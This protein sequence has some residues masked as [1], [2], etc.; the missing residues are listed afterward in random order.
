MEEPICL[1]RNPAWVDT[2]TRPEC[3]YSPVVVTKNP[4]PAA[5]ESMQEVLSTRIRV[6][7]KLGLVNG[8]GWLSFKRGSR[9]VTAFDRHLRSHNVPVIVISGGSGKKIAA[10]LNRNRRLAWHPENVPG[11]PVYLLVHWLDYDNY[12]SAL[13]GA[14]SRY[15]NLRLIGWQGGQMTGFGA[16][17][18]AAL[19]FADSLPYRP[20]RILMVDQDVVE[21]EA[22]RLGRPTVRREVEALHA[23]SRKPVVG[24]GV[25]YPTRVPHVPGPFSTIDAPAANDFNSPAQQLVSVMAPFRDKFKDG[26]YP[27]YMVAGGED[28]LM[29]MELNLICED[30]NI[31]LLDR[32][33]VKKAL[34]GDPDPSNEY[35]DG[36][37]VKTL[38]ELYKEEKN[39]LVNFE[40]ETMEL[41]GLMS[42]FVDLGWIDQKPAAGYPH[43]AEL[44]NTSACVVER[45]ILRLRKTGKFHDNFN[46]VIFN[47]LPSP[48]Q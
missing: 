33:I 28:M 16:A 20:H 45:I 11:E 10:D 17:R 12:A 31:V 43:G 23:T 47:R 30:R 5:I 14:L 29:G 2:N 36:A 42:R 48:I 38:V 15:R 21:T 7:Q 35:W 34:R 41:G 22:T 44:Y 46:G 13:S 8:V 4:N 6:C 24:Y 1:E 37:R 26:I 3:K 9:I 32:K 39:A 27:A 18:A 25:G 19:A 40:G